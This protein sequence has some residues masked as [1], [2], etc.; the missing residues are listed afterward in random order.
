VDTTRFPLIDISRGGSIQ[1]ELDALNRLVTLAIP[2]VPI[3][4]R[5]EGTL[6]I[7]AHGHVCDQFDVVAYRDMV[8]II[9]DR[10]REL[11]TSGKTLEQIK[12]A[13]PAKGYGARYGSGSGLGSTNGFVEAIYRSLSQVKS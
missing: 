7:P 13:A 4:T 6:V 1:G 2:S 11:K 8:T 3:I 10:V 12:A 5:D 9:R